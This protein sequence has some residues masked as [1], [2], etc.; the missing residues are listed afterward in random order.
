MASRSPPPSPERVE[1]AQQTRFGVIGMSCAACTGAVERS[2]R[3]VA[4]VREAQASLATEAVT[5]VHDGVDGAALVAAV[6]AAGYRVAEPGVAGYTAH[7]AEVRRQTRQLALGIACTAPLLALG[8]GRDL[9]LLGAWAHAAWVDWL[10][11]ALATPVQFI[12]GA[13][14]YRGAGRSLRNRSANMDL[15][16]ALGSSVAYLFSLAVLAARTTGG[17]PLGD[18][19]HFATA[20]LIITLIKLGKL[21]EARARGSCGAALQGLIKLRPALARIERGAAVREVPLEAVVVDDV[22]VVRPGEAIPVD[23]EIIAGASIIDESMLTGESLP[24]EREV[25]GS[26]TGGTVNGAGL[27]RVRVTRVGDDTALAQIVRVVQEAQA[28]RAPVQRLADRVAAVFVPVVVAVALG[29]CTAWW[30][31]TGDAAAAI[32]RLTAVLVIACPCALGLATPAAVVV[33][34]GRGAGQGLLFHSATALEQAGRVRTVLFDKTGTL[35][36]GELEVTDVIPTAAG[37]R[38]GGGAGGGGGVGG[39]ARPVR[40]CRWRPAPSRVRSIRWRGRW[41]RPPPHGGW[42]WSRW[43][44]WRRWRASV[45]APPSADGRWW[46]AARG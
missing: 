2:L 7:A 23:G 11:L 37:A 4:G 5:I 20:A 31:A 30:L 12:V 16:V 40:C 8:M 42:C 44:S 3:G 24:V 10:M 1:G 29:V 41:W 19:L 43:K 21:L 26:V 35:T 46:W 18:D 14:Y 25:G 39:R 38:G 34:T 15:L 33:A 36:T 32:L 45:C 13:D 27:L 22:V 17:S 9:G 6:E 28:S